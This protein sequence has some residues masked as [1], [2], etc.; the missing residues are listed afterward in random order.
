MDEDE[1]RKRFEAFFR[2]HYDA[3]LAYAASRADLDTAKDAVAAAFL[4]AWRR[5]GEDREHPLPWLYGVTR[6]TLSDQRRS[7]TRLLALRRKLDAQPLASAVGDDP[8]D[9]S[10]LVALGR[11]READQELLRLSA[12]EG[13]SP[14]DVAEVLSCSRRV[15]TVRLHRARERLKRALA[16]V[17]H[18]GT[19]PLHATGDRSNKETP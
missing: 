17:G 11:L 14:A 13:L 1:R 19:A 2:D 18:E 5:H 15:A 12:W 3:V 4:V 7:A 10:L 6:K 9:G 8:G 16:E